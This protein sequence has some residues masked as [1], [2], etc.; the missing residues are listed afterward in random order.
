MEGDQREG[1]DPAQG[2]D[3]AVV[4]DKIRLDAPAGGEHQRIVPGQV[5]PADRT[6]GDL[7][8]VGERVA[9]GLFDGGG[10]ELKFPGGGMEA[11]NL[12][13]L[14]FPLGNDVV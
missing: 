10:P 7:L 3:L 12:V 11:V 6:L 14:I 9:A 5:R 1:V 13:L 2:F 4:G 8:P